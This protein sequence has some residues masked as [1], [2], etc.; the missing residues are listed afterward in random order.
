MSSPDDNRYPLDWDSRRREVYSRDGFTCQNCGA[1][2]GPR[3]SAELQAHHIVPISDGGS[4][5]KSNLTTLCRQCHDAIHGNSQAP[6][7]NTLR[8]TGRNRLDSVPFADCPVCGKWDGMTLSN[9]NLRIVCRGCGLE[10]MKKEYSGHDKWKIT[11]YRGKSF[12]YMEHSEA[13]WREFSIYGPVSISELEKRYEKKIRQRGKAGFI[14][15]AF[16][17]SIVVGILAQSLIYFIILNL[18]WIF[19]LGAIHLVGKFEND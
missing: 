9:R 3:G 13:E 19:T 17:F 7:G 18:I 4:H 12:S 14:L 8:R 2:G 1:K 5:Q 15:L 10:L 16:S 11:N 6:T